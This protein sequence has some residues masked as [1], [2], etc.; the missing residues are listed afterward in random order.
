MW[1]WWVRVGRA[2]WGWVEWGSGLGQIEVLEA[3]VSETRVSAT[4]LTKT[5]T[6]RV[7]S[8]TYTGGVKVQCCRFLFTFVE[9]V[10]FPRNKG[11]H[12]PD[13]LTLT[14]TSL[15]STLSPLN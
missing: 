4:V 8:A 7:T 14:H 5:P 15:T 9:H 2:W 3:L 12:S 1:L 13:A 10:Q 11:T 6:L